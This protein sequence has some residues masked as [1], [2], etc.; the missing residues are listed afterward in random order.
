MCTTKSIGVQRLIAMSS[1]NKPQI[2][3]LCRLQPSRLTLV[4]ASKALQVFMGLRTNKREPLTMALLAVAPWRPQTKM[5]PERS[6][7]AHLCHGLFLTPQGRLEFPWLN[8]SSACRPKRHSKQRS[9]C[10]GASNISPKLRFCCVVFLC[11]GVKLK[12]H[13]LHAGV[14]MNW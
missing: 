4:G 2:T 1:S 5:Q 9:P 6:D 11:E 14:V 7:V 10:L 13:N 8:A 12:R 3:M